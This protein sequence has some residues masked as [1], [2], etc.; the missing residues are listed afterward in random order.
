MRLEWI[1]IYNRSFEE[2]NLGD[3]I[4]IADDDTNSMANGI[5]LSPR[6][7]AVLA[8]Q[9]IPID[10]SDSFESF[11]GDSSGIWGDSEIENYVALDIDITLG[12]NFGTIILATV[13]SASVDEVSW[14][15]ASDDGRSMERDDIDDYNSGWHDCYDPDGSTPGRMNSPIP[16]SGEESF[17]IVINP[18]VVSVNNN[19]FRDFS[20]EIIIPPACEL[21]VRVFDETGY[22]VKSLV[23]NSENGVL[24]IGWDGKDDKGRYLPPG[25]YIISCILSGRR[26]ESKN[27]PVIIAP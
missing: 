22:K 24:R 21:S 11:W 9:L 6:S 12:N 5:F 8:R 26:N 20:I 15:T 13:E 7:Y 19:D 25:I 23:E 4:L 2:I 27:Y 17:N 3:Y 18:I 10:G 1:E 14:F 16:Q